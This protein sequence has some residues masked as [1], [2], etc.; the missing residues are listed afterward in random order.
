MS[1]KGETPDRDLLKRLYPQREHQNE[2]FV[3]RER[4][5]TH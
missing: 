1:H 4:L 5:A 3:D 2:D